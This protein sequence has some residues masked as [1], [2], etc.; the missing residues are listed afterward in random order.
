MT[1]NLNKNLL[2][3]KKD[4]NSSLDLTPY[5]RSYQAEYADMD[6]SSER[7]AAGNYV[8]DYIRTVRTVKCVLRLSS[9]DELKQI[10]PF[11]KEKSLN[12]K[13]YDM[14]NPSGITENGKT[15]PYYSEAVMYPSAT[16]SV[17]VYHTD[18]DDAVFQEFSLDLVEF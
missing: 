15:L 2:I 17:S 14:E 6:G 4:D 13:F 1:D 18:N 12:V 9:E 16:R 10:M 8:R 3:L 7:C 11:L 5:L